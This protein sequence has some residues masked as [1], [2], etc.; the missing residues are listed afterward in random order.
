MG[1]ELEW[2]G[3]EDEKVAGMHWGYEETKIFL[4]IRSESWIHEKLCTCHRNRQVYRIVAE[5]LQERG[6]LRTLEQ[7]R[8]RFKNLQTN[9]R[10]ARSTHTPG[11]CPLYDEMDAL[12][13]PWTLANTFD[14]LEDL[15]FPH[16]MGSQVWREVKNFGRTVSRISRKFGKLPVQI[17]KQGQR[18]RRIQ[19][20]TFQRQ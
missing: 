10:K 5:R 4:G 2:Q 19:A 18:M 12:M 6:F 14:A 8:Y 3:L 7:C 20:R 11:T 17:L 13:S 9:Y 1:D 15:Q 16:Q